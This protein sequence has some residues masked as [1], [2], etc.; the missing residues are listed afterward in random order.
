M[1]DLPER[2]W[3]DRTPDG[4]DWWSADPA[5]VVIPIM[6]EYVRADVAAAA[7]AAALERA[8]GIVGECTVWCAPNLRATDEWRR[9]VTDCQRD[10]A[11]AIAALAKLDGGKG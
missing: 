4:V 2:I 8:A 3:A 1:S 11:A 10:V 5:P 6:T 9:G 7:V